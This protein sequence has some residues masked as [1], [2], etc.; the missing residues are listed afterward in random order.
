[1]SYTKEDLKAMASDLCGIDSN[2]EGVAAINKVIDYLTEEAERDEIVIRWLP[3][4]IQSLKPEWSYER[5][6]EVLDEIS[7]AF[8]D[9]NTE[10]G[11]EILEIMVDE[12]DEESE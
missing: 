2:S 3:D 11:W 1:M 6:V 8:E 9:R 12:Q 5:C 7:G 10:T 4:D